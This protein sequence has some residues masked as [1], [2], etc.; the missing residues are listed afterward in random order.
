[1]TNQTLGLSHQ[2]YDYLLSVSLREPEVLTQLRK[3]TAQLSIGQ[4][5]IAPEQG[6]F[7]ALLVQLLGAKKKRW[8]SGC[9]RVI[10]L[11]LWQWLCR[12]MEKLWPVM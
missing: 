1:M 11:W 2:I 8:K 7:M 12:R 5:Q 6:Q 10:A 9:L 3:E 4:M